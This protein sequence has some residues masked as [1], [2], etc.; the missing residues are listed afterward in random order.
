MKKEK[1]S[2]YQTEKQEHTG[3]SIVRK[4][5]AYLL[6]R[7]AVWQVHIEYRVR[8]WIQKVNRFEKRKWTCY[9][10]YPLHDQRES[11]TILDIE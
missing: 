4:F 8:R 6:R 2:S 3:S 11:L 7:H 10:P 5:N 9:I 1:E